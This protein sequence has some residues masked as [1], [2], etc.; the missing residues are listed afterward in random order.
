G[1]RAARHARCTAATIAKPQSAK[2]RPSGR[3]ILRMTRR[4][5]AFDS[6]FRDDGDRGQHI[7]LVAEARLDLVLLKA[8]A[9]VEED[10]R[11]KV[12]ESPTP[13]ASE[14]GKT[15][16]GEDPPIIGDGILCA[17]ARRPTNA[18]GGKVIR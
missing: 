4:I 3:V 5:Q 1:P 15:V 14:I 2:T 9:A 8:A 10:A 12:G 18:G 7:E 16:F 13:Y 11:G 6:V 17:A